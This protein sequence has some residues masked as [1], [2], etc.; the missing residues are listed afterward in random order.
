MAKCV[1]LAANVLFWP[2]VVWQQV[3]S[4]DIMMWLQ[5]ANDRMMLHQQQGFWACAALLLAAHS[6]LLQF[7]I[8][9]WIYSQVRNN[10]VMQ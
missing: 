9:L 10:M 1:P 8:F 7:N 6:K 3:H 4:N 5:Q 2:G